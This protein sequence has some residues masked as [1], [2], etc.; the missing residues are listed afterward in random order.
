MFNIYGKDATVSS[1]EFWD[2]TTKY[3]M[4]NNFLNKKYTNFLQI[5][6][7]IKYLMTS[8]YE[9]FDFLERISQ[10]KL[11]HYGVLEN[12]FLHEFKITPDDLVKVNVYN[13]DKI[14]TRLPP[15]IV[16]YKENIYIN[17]PAT[18]LAS[19]QLEDILEIKREN[20]E[21]VEIKYCFE[22][23]TFKCRITKKPDETEPGVSFE[24]PEKTWLDESKPGYKNSM[25]MLAVLFE[26]EI[27]KPYFVNKTG[28][29]LTKIN[30][31][32]FVELTQDG[33]YFWVMNNDGLLELTQNPTDKFFICSFRNTDGIMT[34]INNNHH[35][36]QRWGMPQLTEDEDLL[37]ESPNG[38]KFVD[39]NNN[40]IE[41]KSDGSIVIS[42]GTA[43]IIMNG[44]NVEIDGDFSVSGVST[45]TGTA[46]LTVSSNI[47]EIND[48]LE[49]DPPAGLRS[50]LLIHRGTR[51]DYYFV[52]DETDFTLKGGEEGNLKAISQREQ[53]P[54]NTGVP[55][56]DDANKIFKTSNQMIWNGNQLIVDADRVDGLHADDNPISNNDTTLATK[57]KVKKYTDDATNAIQTELT[58]HKDNISN[59]HSVTKAQVGLANTPNWSGSTNVALGTSNSTIP[60]QGAVKAYVDALD[61]R[62]PWSHFT[63]ENNPH[64]VTK[65]QV[66]LGD[67]PN[68]KPLHTGNRNPIDW[69]GNVFDDEFVSAKL[70]K[71]YID[72]RFLNEVD[73]IHFSRLDNPHEVTKAQVGLAD[74]PNW[75]PGGEIL[76]DG[77]TSFARESATKNYIDTR[78]ANHHELHDIRYYRKG[79]VDNFLDTKLN[80]TTHN[81]FVS[82]NNQ[83][84]ID[85]LA[86]LKLNLEGNINSQIST[87]NGVIFQNKTEIGLRVDELED[88]INDA[89]LDLG[90]NTTTEIN[91]A[92]STLNSRIT[93]EVHA[94]EDS[95][96]NNVHSIRT[97]MSAE[98]VALNSR[99][100][101]EVNALDTKITNNKNDIESRVTNEVNTL[102]NRI[103]SEVSDLNSTINTKETTLD[104]RI[105]S[106][107][108]D[109]NSI[110]NSKETTLDNRITSEVNTLN[111]RIDDEVEDLEES[112]ISEVAALN[113]IINT[114]ET[115]LDNRITS[116]VNTLNSS[117]NL[118]ANS[119]DVYTRTQLYTKTEADNLL[120]AKAN[121][122]HTH[123]GDDITSPVAKAHNSES[124]DI[125]ED[126]INTFHNL[127][128]SDGFGTEKSLFGSD[129][130]RFNPASGDL[131]IDGA[132]LA[133]LKLF[134]IEHPV[135]SSKKLRH[136][137]IESSKADVVY[138]GMVKLEDGLAEI[139]IDAYA[140]MEEGTFVAMSKNV[141]RMTSNETG[142][143]PVKSVLN[144]NILSI[145]C[146]DLMSDDEVYW[147]ITF[148]R[149][150][151]DI[152]FSDLTDANGSLVVEVSKVLLEE[153]RK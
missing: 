117:I 119:A 89:L 29:D 111:S 17:K 12:S 67:V 123:S 135:N 49:G 74:V 115:T 148:E 105:T 81:L 87:V 59:P 27:W 55:F 25:E 2:G 51:P 140:G 104:N 126:S 65:A 69:V 56:W 71:E 23:D 147:Q 64:K 73:T 43:S 70:I 142:F 97:D 86:A 39:A 36:Y 32:Q 72:Y 57:N 134:E 114:K 38:F 11:T 5:I 120:N 107:V 46:T 19:K 45:S 13:T 92:V 82:S 63:N 58:N 152:I 1:S 91:S 99:I 80:I 30:I 102:D 68:W 54:V 136:V 22:T 108:S 100:D 14:Y 18:V 145:E 90:N 76:S 88:E 7:D 109:L 83:R 84:I 37:F 93:S 3:N 153:T 33:E 151:A 122:N 112:I 52:F 143:S 66:G 125:T 24:Y 106:E 124:I 118:K 130:A 95:I 20:Q 21:S 62:I 127:I 26:D 10:L 94:L 78:I 121:T 103:T 146:E 131:L 53:N 61:G 138:S 35:L 16:I 50:G 101:N 139:N 137:A 149:N 129:K 42:N 113:S 9:T 132:I 150:D 8:Y 98:V 144:G 77:V 40:T 47:I 60:S 41:L 44:N 34:D 96:S 31:E 15:G 75:L 133:N 28:N 4:L 110:I 79:E 116:E 85:D 128:L 48:G 6:P 141:R